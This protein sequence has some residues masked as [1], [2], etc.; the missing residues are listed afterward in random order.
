M[1]LRFFGASVLMLASLAPCSAP[2]VANLR[3]PF[4]FYLGPALAVGMFA[5]FIMNA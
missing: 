4:A 1:W 3:G 2:D 5:G